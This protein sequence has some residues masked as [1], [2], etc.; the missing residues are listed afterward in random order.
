MQQTHYLSKVMRL[1]AKMKKGNDPPLVRVFDGFNGEWL[2]EI[3][4]PPDDDT[5]DVN[6]Y[7]KGIEGIDVMTF[8]CRR[9]V[10]IN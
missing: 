6:N 5:S 3:F 4:T 2:C 7:N 10:H 8:C 1:F 9:D